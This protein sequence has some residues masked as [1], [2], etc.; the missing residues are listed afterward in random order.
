[1]RTCAAN[2]CDEPFEPIRPNQL[3]CSKTCKNRELIRRFR[4]KRRGETPTPP[5]T[6]P[7]PGPGRVIEV[8]QSDR[9][10]TLKAESANHDRVELRVGDLLRIGDQE[11]LITGIM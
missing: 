5:P 7:K 4:A 1:M 11:C 9:G 3:F 10:V 8:V 6:P 2:D